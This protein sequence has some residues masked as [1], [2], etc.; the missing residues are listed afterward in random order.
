[1]ELS[2]PAVLGA[3]I[4]ALIAAPL[5]PRARRWAFGLLAL[6]AV[7][8]VASLARFAK[9]KAIS[10]IVEAGQRAA[11]KSAIWRLREVVIAQDGMRKTARIDPDG[12]GIGSAGFIAALAGRASHRHGNPETPALLNFRFRKI[13]ETAT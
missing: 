2:I 5:P 10:G 8:S 11:A 6:S 4:A 13:V 12:D 7:I 9:G 3:L 1:I